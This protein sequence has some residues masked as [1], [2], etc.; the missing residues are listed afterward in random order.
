MISK[1]AVVSFKKDPRKLIC[2]IFAAVFVVGMVFATI[3]D[4]KISAALTN[5]DDGERLS[6]TVPFFALI[7]EIIGEWPSN[8]LGSFCAAVIMRACI[9]TKKL[10]GYAAGVGFG[11][12]ATYFVYQSTSSSAEGI[13]EL[14]NAEY[15]AKHLAFVIPITII[16]AAALFIGIFMLSEK[17]AKKLLVPCIVCGSM[18]A[19]MFA[20]IQG[21]KLL[22]GRVRMRQLVE[23]GDLSRFTPWYKISP[24]SGFRSFPSGHTANAVSLGLLPLLYSK[25]ITEKSPYAKKV[26]YIFVAVWGAFMAFTRILVGAH[27]LSDVLCGAAIAFVCVILGHYFMDKI[28]NA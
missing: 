3:F 23:L 14:A 9:K 19:L 12:I 28:R 5:L 10:L 6:I 8:M 21:C 16:I 22:W 1:K 7:I 27:F 13:V 15:T 18:L 17:T 20:G 26:T 4:F 24:F 25:N 2:L 11:A